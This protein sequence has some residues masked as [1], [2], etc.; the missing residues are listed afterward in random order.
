[1]SKQELL[2]LVESLGS[3]TEDLKEENDNLKKAVANEHIVIENDPTLNPDGSRTS[4]KVAVKV[5]EDGNELISKE[6]VVDEKLNLTVKHKVQAMAM[7]EIP[8]VL[9]SPEQAVAIMQEDDK[10]L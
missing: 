3:R 5:D 8:P 10:V 1:M 2:E 4:P 9:L 6:K 7:G